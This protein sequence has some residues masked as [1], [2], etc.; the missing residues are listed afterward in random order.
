MNAH[1]TLFAVNESCGDEP[2]DD[3]LMYA[4]PIASPCRT[5]PINTDSFIYRFFAGLQPSLSSDGAELRF[6]AIPYVGK[7]KYV[8][9]RA[10]GYEPKRLDYLALGDSFSSGEGD[11]DDSHYLVGTN[12]EFEKCHVSDRSYPFLLARNM[13][14]EPEY[15]R[16]V[17][18]S[19]ARTLDL[20]DTVAYDGQGGRLGK[21][22]ARLND[23]DMILSKNVALDNFLAGRVRQGEFVER[24]RPEIVTLG[25]GGNDVGFMEKLKSCVGPG[26]CDVA[27][28][29][30]KREQT[31]EEIKNLFGTLVDTY[32]KLHNDSPDTK[33]YVVGYPNV[34]STTS[35]CPETDFWLNS[36]ERE[37]MYNGVKYLNSVI[38]AASRAAGVKYVDIWDSFSE[39]TICGLEQ[40]TAMNTIKLGDDINPMGESRFFRLIGAES[41]HPNPLGH[42]LTADL[43]SRRYGNLLD[44]NYCQNG[45]VACPNDQ[46]VAPEPPDYWHDGDSNRLPIQ[47]SIDIIKDVSIGLAD[48]LTDIATKLYHTVGLSP[49]SFAPG[50]KVTVEVHSTPMVIGESYANSDGSASLGFSLPD[51]LEE[52]Y[53]ELHILGDSYTGK[54]IDY[55]QVFLF[56]KEIAPKVDDEVVEEVG[57]SSDQGS[58]ESGDE[59]TNQDD[60]NEIVNE[61]LPN[62]EEFA[63]EISD[64]GEPINTYLG[65][66][67]TP[68]KIMVI[69]ETRQI[70]DNSNSSLGNQLVYNNKSS[71]KAATSSEVVDD[72]KIDAHNIPNSVNSDVLGVVDKVTNN[73]LYYFVWLVLVFVAALITT[74]AFIKR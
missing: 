69:N 47:A 27:I 11:N 43:I 30:Q 13:G 29:P 9:L 70:K 49:M 31:A 65:E 40:P 18:C 67:P 34:V 64:S 58:I 12:D 17:A 55:Y 28:N 48:T 7:A 32:K 68:E 44:L 1:M 52:G 39:K 33:I 15:M 2:T 54:K 74:K 46:V 3:R 10:G 60:D 42:S 21:N 4:I 56:S 66:E 8:T 20:Y 45:E 73:F 50:T 24:Y 23:V 36:N 53:H 62:N 72:K 19:S 14:I 5:A 41:L 71:E 51:D 38:E 22:G 16:S 25:V 6:Y 35:Y 26:T 59:A 63:D 37:F 57:D 61:E